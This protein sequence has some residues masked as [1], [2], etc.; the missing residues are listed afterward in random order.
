MLP[1]A[2][3]QALRLLSANGD[4]GFF[5]MI[6]GSHIDNGATTTMRKPYFPKYGI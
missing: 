5:V 4:K 2:T 6:E 1:R 3:D